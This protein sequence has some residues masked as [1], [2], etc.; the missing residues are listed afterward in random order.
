MGVPVRV[1]DTDGLRAWHDRHA[2]PPG[3]TMADWSLRK[4]EEFGATAFC[5]L[6]DGHR[7][8]WICPG[9]GVLSGGELGNEPVSGWDNPRWVNSG[10]RERPTLTP[11]L[12]CPEWRRGEC[13]GHWWLRDGV[14]EVA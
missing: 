7:F 3:E 5:W 10:T 8:S 13:M 6:P 9:C 12:G 2:V 11:S 4:I 14:L 1:V